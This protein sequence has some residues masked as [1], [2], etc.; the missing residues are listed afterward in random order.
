[1]SGLSEK[2]EVPTCKYKYGQDCGMPE[3]CEVASCQY[4]YGQNTGTS[5]TDDDYN[6]KG[7]PVFSCPVSSG[8]SQ[9]QPPEE[10]YKQ[11]PVH[12]MYRT[13]NTD[14]GAEPPTIHT[15]PI[16]FHAKSQQFSNDLG[17]CGMYRNSSLNTGLDSSNIP[18]H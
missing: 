5:S 14:Y 17:K 2:C 13:T 8:Q 18:D 10:E 3:R 1:M 11:K 16:T 12:P 9:A 4:R 7:N 15:V 6:N